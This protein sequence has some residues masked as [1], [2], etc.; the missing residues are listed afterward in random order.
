MEINGSV[1]N[2]NE[3][4]EKKQSEM[5][6][7]KYIQKYLDRMARLDELRR[8][9]CTTILFTTSTPATISHINTKSARMEKQCW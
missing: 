4:F 2:R 6:I 9:F 7:R 5:M 8:I 1:P 3:A